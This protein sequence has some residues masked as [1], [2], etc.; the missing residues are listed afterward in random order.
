VNEPDGRLNDPEG[1]ENDPEGR[2]NEPDGR[3]GSVIPAALR[4]VVTAGLLNRA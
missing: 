3:A 1:R 4:Q 2:L